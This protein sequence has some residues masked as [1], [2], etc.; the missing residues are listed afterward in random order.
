MGK[1][2]R[3]WRE[4]ET[5]AGALFGAVSAW[6][7]RRT[8][9]F[10][11]PQCREFSWIF[12]GNAAA[13]RCVV[14]GRARAFAFAGRGRQKVRRQTDTHTL[15]LYG[16]LRVPESPRSTVRIASALV[17]RNRQ[18]RVLSGDAPARSGCADETNVFA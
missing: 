10:D 17:N 8:G 16:L 3:A 5:K 15:E 18:H 9:S 14:C 2:N 13:G 12:R 11:R 1:A 7:W 6:R 4:D